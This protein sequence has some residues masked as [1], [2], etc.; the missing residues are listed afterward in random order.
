MAL[1]IRVEDS[2]GRG[3]A[4]DRLEEVARALTRGE[5]FPP[6]I[7]VGE[8]HEELVCLEGHLRLTAHALAGFPVAVECLVGTAPTM[9]HWAR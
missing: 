9:G 3:L 5:Q 8:K 2:V 4:L 1:L 6:L 7:L